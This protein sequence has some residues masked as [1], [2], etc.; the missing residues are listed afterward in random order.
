MNKT[1]ISL[2]KT[3]VMMKTLSKQ[4]DEIIKTNTTISHNHLQFIIKGDMKASLKIASLIESKYY[5]KEFVTYLLT[6]TSYPLLFGEINE[7]N[8]EIYYQ[9]W[10]TN[11]RE[12]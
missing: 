12:K 4:I 5:E 8:T 7:A 11:I 9:D 10:L 1:T 2:I 3:Y 6:E